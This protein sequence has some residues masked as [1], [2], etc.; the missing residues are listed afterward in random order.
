[1]ADRSKLYDN[2]NG[3]KDQAE[4]AAERKE[5]TPAERAR[6]KKIA[7]DLA[8]GKKFPVVEVGKPGPKSDDEIE[9]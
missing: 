5:P 4:D 1:M 8:K 3:A 7:D 9:K 6:N 2:P